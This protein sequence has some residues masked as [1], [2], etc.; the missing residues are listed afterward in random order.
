MLL[1][2]A[3]P[4]YNLHTVGRNESKTMHE[5]S[6]HGKLGVMLVNCAAQ[7]VFPQ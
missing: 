2:F 7:C 6:M 5:K 3:T 1:T 4:D